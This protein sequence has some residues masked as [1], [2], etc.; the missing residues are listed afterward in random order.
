[1]TQVEIKNLALKIAYNFYS[2]LNLPRHSGVMAEEYEKVIK[3]ISKDYCIV[4]KELIRKEY[5]KAQKA[6]DIY[7]SATCI[8]EMESR[9]IDHAEG[10]MCELKTLF[11]KSLFEEEK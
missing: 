2:D 6:H 1:M 3:E 8:N 10:R 4:P 9:A 5:A 11:G 7:T